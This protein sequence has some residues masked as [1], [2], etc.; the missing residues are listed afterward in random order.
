MNEQSTSILDFVIGRGIKQSYSVEVFRRGESKVLASSSFHFAV[1]LM[2]DFV[3]DRVDFD[4]TDPVGRLARIKALGLRLYTKLFGT[5]VLRAWQEERQ[6]SNFV[7]ISLSFSAEAAALQGLPWEALYDGSVFISVGLGTGLSRRPNRFSSS[8]RTDRPRPPLRMIVFAS[9]PL[10]LTDDER[11]QVELEQDAI[12]RAVRPQIDRGAMIVD[13]QDEATLENFSDVLAADY[14]IIHITGHGLSLR[15][16]GGILFEDDKGGSRGVTPGELEA[17]FRMSERRSR[18]VVISA[19]QSARA[20]QFAGTNLAN[21][22]ISTGVASVVAMQFTLSDQA[23]L[24]FAQKMYGSI[25]EG[26]SLE[27][28]VT[29]GRRVLLSTPSPQLQADAIA[30]VL[31]VADGECLRTSEPVAAPPKDTAYF[32]RALKQAFLGRRRELRIIRDAL[33]NDAR[34]VVIHGLVGIGKTALA[35]ESAQRLAPHFQHV[36]FLDA[37]KCSTANTL[38]NAI[39]TCGIHNEPKEKQA[40][41]PLQSR[42]AASSGASADA[43]VLIVIDGFEIFLSKDGG[44]VRISDRSLEDLLVSWIGSRNNQCRFLIMSRLSFCFGDSEPK[45]VRQ[46]ALGELSATETDGLVRSFDIERSQTLREIHVWSKLLPDA[47]GHPG[48]LQRLHRRTTGLVEL[49]PV[50]AK[51][52]CFEAFKEVGVLDVLNTLSK[53]SRDLFSRISVFRG[54]I[55]MTAISWVAAAEVQSGAEELTDELFAFKWRDTS[56]P[57]TDTLQSA[58]KDLTSSAALTSELCS[59]GILNPLNASGK[60]FSISTPLATHSEATLAT[61]TRRHYLRIA[62]SFWLRQAGFGQSN[63]ENVIGSRCALKALDLLIESEDCDAAADLLLWVS[64]RLIR[65][66]HSGSLRT[67]FESIIDKVSESKTGD[68][69]LNFGIVLQYSGELSGALSHCNKALEFA[70]KQQDDTLQARCLHQIGRLYDERGVELEAATHYH[71]A[72]EKATLVGDMDQL[73]LTLHQLASLQLG[74]GNLDVALETH[75]QA[76][77]IKERQ[78]NLAGVARSIHQIALIYQR[79]GEDAKA[80]A[81]FEESLEIKKSTGDLLGA[82]HSL[83]QIGKIHFD[84]KDYPKALAN[85]A[86][87]LDILKALGSTFDVAASLHAIGEMHKELGDLESALEEF[88]NSLRLSEEHGLV[89]LAVTTLNEIGLIHQERR[90]YR[91]AF[92]VNSR[93]LQLLKSRDYKHGKCR[94][95][96]E[97]GVISSKMGNSQQAMECLH[98]GLAL[99][100]EV[101]DRANEGTALANLSLEEADLGRYQAAAT[102]SAEAVQVARGLTY[103]HLLAVSLYSQGKA[104]NVLG[105]T[106][107][108]LL[109]FE[110]SL[111]LYEAT[112]D[113]S[114]AATVLASIGEIYYAM[115]LVQEALHRYKQALSFACEC[116]DQEQQARMLHL[117]GVVHL[118]RREFVEAED[119]F[120][121]SLVAAQAIRQTA[122]CGRARHQLA[123]VYHGRGQL[124]KA[125][126]LFREALTNAQDA[127]D[128]EQI[129]ATL[130]NMG[131][132]YYDEWRQDSNQSAFTAAVE[133]LRGAIRAKGQSPKSAGLLETFQLLVELLIRSRDYEQAVGVLQEMLTVGEDVHQRRLSTYAQNTLGMVLTKLGRRRE[134]MKY[135]VLSYHSG[136]TEARSTAADLLRE[137]RAEWGERNFA[138]AW[139]QTGN[140]RS[141]FTP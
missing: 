122:Q 4:P 136:D 107:A 105:D 13:V 118:L 33:T 94:T 130:H 113:L 83:H 85:M 12:R 104:R 26:E 16:G 112:T 68:L 47:G 62:A 36:V 2:A 90:E 66:G 18:L 110:E 37:E 72:I 70:K 127:A 35:Q 24:L 77:S 5:E 43:S 28:A 131:M 54:T 21:R 67:R 120:T 96:I 32:P 114:R 50:V 59:F 116:Q 87:A 119:S 126:E 45:G 8:S 61:D 101:G 78:G 14:D 44:C 123:C 75:K 71:A 25:T 117:I 64:P 86:Q 31:F 80:V 55:S 124:K 17:L 100:R 111:Q 141:P 93:A 125:L 41:T 129:G 138:T 38:K 30:P 23:G 63:T 60:A 46:I 22:L 79:K 95:L 52:V 84:R 15:E 40:V 11:L 103:P 73:S 48:I 20:P 132:I 29:Q 27:Q 133:A 106:D 42:A 102:L 135:L 69:E 99:A 6:K 7:N 76:R 108:A 128:N 51:R 92:A 91:A 98:E 53:E 56:F 10:D 140:G 81:L 65:S 109:S 97:R 115:G 1:S 89:E 74:Q 58:K 137:L 49:D 39:L 88:T 82:G 139:E 9:S 19:C 121:N 3:I 134:A 34:A 57:S